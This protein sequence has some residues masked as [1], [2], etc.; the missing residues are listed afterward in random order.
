MEYLYGELDRRT[1]SALEEH[2]KS[3]DECRRSLAEWRGAMGELD[4]WKVG[5]RRPVVLWLRPALRWAVAALLLL[6]V[7]FGVGRVS[8]RGTADAEELR[9]EWRAALADAE[10]RLREEI[11]ADVQ[12]DI[13]ETALATLSTANADATRLMN[14]YAAAFDST[15]RD[16]LLTLAALTEQEFARTRRQMASALTYTGPAAPV[17]ESPSDQTQANQGG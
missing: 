12:E 11:R 1:R 6:A 4:A 2:L 3:C 8:S 16:D 13:N 14:R 5:G 9:A 15:R 17:S 10:S 7:G